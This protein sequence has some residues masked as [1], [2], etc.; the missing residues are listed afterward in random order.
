MVKLTVLYGKPTDAALKQQ[1]TSRTSPQ[2][3]PPS[4]SAA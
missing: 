1:K 2:A 4:S 3:A